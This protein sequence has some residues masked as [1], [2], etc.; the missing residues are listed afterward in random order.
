[1]EALLREWLTSRPL[2]A[3]LQRDAGVWLWSLC[4]TFHFVGLCLLIGIV[5]MFDLRVLGMAKGLP[6]AALKRLLP[7]G[8][9]GFLICLMTG[10]VFVLGMGANTFGESA[11]DVIGRDGYLQLK[12]GFIFL[13]GLNVLAFYL[14]GSA[15]RADDLGAGDDAPRLAKVIAGTSLFLWI[16]VII[17]GRLIQRAL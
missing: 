17:F 8:V 5:G 11:Y 14:T 15:R 1:M 4:E 12:L 13:A 6:L 2:T 10:M 9:L 16:G 3:F 7:W